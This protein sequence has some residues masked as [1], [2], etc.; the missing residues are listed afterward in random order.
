MFEF[1]QS[2][3]SGCAVDRRRPAVGRRSAAVGRSRFW[4]LPQR[5]KGAGPVERKLAS[6]QEWRRACRRTWQ[7]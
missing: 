4:G 2:G 6:R 1:T 5:L 7:P 3:C